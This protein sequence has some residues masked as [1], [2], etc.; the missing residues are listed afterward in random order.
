MIE[1]TASSEC[2]LSL[3]M[4]GEDLSSSVSSD[5]SLRGRCRVSSDPSPILLGQGTHGEVHRILWRGEI[6]AEK[7]PY[8]AFGP[9]ELGISRV[10]MRGGVDLSHLPR[11]YDVSEAGIVMELIP[12]EIPMRPEGEDPDFKVAHKVA[13][14]LCKALHSIE[15]A[16]GR[17][18][19]HR[20]LKLA[21]MRMRHDGSF[22][23]LDFGTMV[24]K[25][26]KADPRGNPET[27]AHEAYTNAPVHET[28]D[29]WSIG[30]IMYQ[31]LTGKQHPVIKGVSTRPFEFIM[32]YVANYAIS[33]REPE[34]SLDEFCEE[35]MLDEKLDS[36]M[37]YNRELK[38]EIESLKLRAKDKQDLQTLELMWGFLDPDSFT[39][40]QTKEALAIMGLE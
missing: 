7:M 21:N 34:Q 32:N 33:V 1:S 39:R 20:D 25:G 31:I 30:V 27:V 29:S 18:Y 37:A 3:A 10:L 12:H 11:V 8:T 40:L 16:T 28:L 14:S 22:V 17:V 24:E 6:C 9:D 19:V 35:E 15:Q 36:W 38:G 13:R 23:L 26:S 5:F 2:F 4:A